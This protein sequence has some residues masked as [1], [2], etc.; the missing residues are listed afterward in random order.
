M[1]TTYCGYGS[2]ADS[3]N[4]KIGSFERRKLFKHKESLN[5]GLSNFLYFLETVINK[6]QMSCECRNK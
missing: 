5:L 1:Y 3:P 6:H 4:L 2:Q